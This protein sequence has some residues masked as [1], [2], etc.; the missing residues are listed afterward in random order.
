MTRVLSFDQVDTSFEIM[1][2]PS[3]QCTTKESMTPESR[4]L[5]NRIIKE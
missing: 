5:M 1:G 2:I 3:V 4:E